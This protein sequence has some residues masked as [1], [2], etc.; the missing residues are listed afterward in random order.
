[1]LEGAAITNLISLLLLIATGVYVYLTWR[2]AQSNTQILKETQRAFIEDRAPYI[3]VRITVTQSSLLNLEIQN[4]G[5]SPAKNLKLSL[6]RDFYQFGKFQESKNI[7]MRHAFQN[8]IPQLAPGECLRFALSQGF[9]LDKFHESRA[10]TPKIFCIKAEY[11]YNGNR[12]TS[13][14]TVDLNSL[15]GNSFE[16]T[17]SERLLEIEGVMRKWKL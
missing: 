8:E 13:E 4:I 1:M 14:H 15:M 12:R 10:L 11:D 9:N 3:T 5:R 6:D 7:R 17:V 2:I 16:R